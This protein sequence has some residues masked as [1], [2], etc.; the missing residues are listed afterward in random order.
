M[1]KTRKSKS[2]Y[3]PF[4]ETKGYRIEQRRKWSKIMRER[5]RHRPRATPVL[6]SYMP[7]NKC[8]EKHDRRE[9]CGS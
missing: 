3:V 9:P 1:M 7:C 6:V 8:G 5:K 2:R 4:W